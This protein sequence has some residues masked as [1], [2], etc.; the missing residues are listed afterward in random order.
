MYISPLRSIVNQAG[1][2]NTVNL[3]DRQKISPFVAPPWW[4]GPDLH[5][6]TCDDEARLQH[7]NIVA[8][9]DNTCIYTDGS[10]IQ[11][12][13]GAAAVWPAKQMRKSAYMG[14]ETTSTVYAA[15]LKASAERWPWCRWTYIKEADTKV[16]TSLQ[17]T[18]QQSAR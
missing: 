5:I 4:H 18:R 8:N 6:A 9:K 1:V 7:D 2:D 14:P 17:I 11:G 13:A 10:C 15:E 16:Y 12:H 3:S